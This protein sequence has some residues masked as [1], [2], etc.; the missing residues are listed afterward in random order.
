MVFHDALAPEAAQD[1]DHLVHALPA[2]REIDAVQIV[3]V[4][5]PAGAGAECHAPAAQDVQGTDGPRD[6]EGIAQRQHVDRYRHVQA[7]GRRRDRAERGPH[8]G[9]PG[10]GAHRRPAVG[11]IGVGRLQFERIDA[12]IG[13]HHAVESHVLGESRRGDDLIGFHPRQHLPE[14]HRRSSLVWMSCIMQWRRC[15]R[16]RVALHLRVAGCDHAN[17]R[18]ARRHAS[19]QETEILQPRILR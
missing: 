9:I 17:R 2:C 19:G 16:E 14:F 15:R 13:E 1:L 3:L 12:V 10:V 5:H 8:V 7:R 4:L 11:G 6:L 18:E